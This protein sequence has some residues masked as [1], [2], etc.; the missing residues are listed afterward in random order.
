MDI[1]IPGM[2]TCDP[3]PNVNKV[4]ALGCDQ[5]R[6]SM[7]YSQ[8]EPWGDAEDA[9]KCSNENKPDIVFQRLVAEVSS[10][11]RT[12]VRKRKAQTPT[13]PLMYSNDIRKSIRCNETFKGSEAAKR[14]LT[15]R[16]QKHS[17]PISQVEQPVVRGA[18]KRRR[19]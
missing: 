11:V 18:G 1:T 19:K 8:N 3:L 6:K 2:P 15:A 13:L 10:S 9:A 14:Y 5:I 17:R 7:D 4:E 12:N 16:A